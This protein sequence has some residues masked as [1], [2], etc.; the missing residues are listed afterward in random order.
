MRL[1]RGW[2]L[3]ALAG[4]L[5]AGPVVWAALRHARQRSEAMSL[6][7][8]AATAHQRVSYS[9]QLSWRRGRWGRP[10][11]V[12]HDQESGRTL[13]GWSV[14]WS[15]VA[16]RPSTKAPDPVAWCRN[17]AA[18]ER[19]YRAEEGATS[20]YLG[21]AVRLLRLNPRHEGRPIVELTVD[22]ETDL[23][24]KVTTFHPDG[25]LAKVVAF[26]K[27]RFAPQKVPERARRHGRSRSI[28]IE[29][30]SDEISFQPL[31]PA[32]LPEGFLLSGCRVSGISV[33]KLTFV[34]TD[35]ISKLELTQG[36]IPTPAQMETEYALRY[37]ARR[38]KRRM[39]WYHEACK[40]R[41]VQ[42]DSS[43]SGKISAKRR[44]HG[45]YQTYE[46]TVGNRD[47]ELRS[48]VDLPA[49]ESA[50]LLR[51]LRAP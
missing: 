10:V 40:R 26:R 17:L 41:I 27:I 12:A 38:A 15:Y 3:L 21:R 42:S 49:E 31:S 36:V 34:Y 16:S 44:R 33:R 37:G 20:R 18:V 50:R 46:L 1:R 13:Y 35:G 29:R 5:A 8:R 51:S 2:L 47:V 19:N 9:G 28:P 7:R 45:R 22:T 11:Y 32:Y 14:R 23:P 43:A 25:S 6:V 4:L 24:L 39:Q 30:I 48:P